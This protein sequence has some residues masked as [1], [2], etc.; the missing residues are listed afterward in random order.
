MVILEKPKESGDIEV[1]GVEKPK[2]KGGRPKGRKNKKH[3]VNPIDELV[4]TLRRM[5]VDIKGKKE[6][7]SSYYQAYR[8]ALDLQSK[9]GK[10]WEISG[11]ELA[12]RNLEAERQL[13]EEGYLDGGK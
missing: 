2:N 9:S 8:Q 5:V 13:K 3:Y 6:L 4:G 12:R 11:D 1:S 7:P 10:N